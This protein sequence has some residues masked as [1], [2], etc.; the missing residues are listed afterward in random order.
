MSPFCPKRIEKGTYSL[1][2]LLLVKV[3]NSTLSQNEV[4]RAESLS[5]ISDSI[6]LY[7]RLIFCFNLAMRD[8]IP[9]HLLVVYY[10]LCL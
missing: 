9:I 3:L 1:I 6:F 8:V 10:R 2:F 7:Y 5:K 4:F